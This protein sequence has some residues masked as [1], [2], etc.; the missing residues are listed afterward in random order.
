MNHGMQDRRYYTRYKLN[1][2]N[3]QGEIPFA[4]NVKILNMSLSG[5]LL[6]T[7]KRPDIGNRYILKLESEGKILTLQGIVIRSEINKGNQDSQENIVPTYTVGI[8]FM[9][10]EDEKLIEIAKFIKDHIL[11]D[12]EQGANIT[13]PYQQK[14]DRLRLRLLIEDPERASLYKRQIYY[15]VT[16]ISLSGMRIESEHEM[17]TDEILLMEIR[18]PEKKILSFLGKIMSCNLSEDTVSGMYQ[19]GIEFIDMSEQ[20]KQIL[21]DFIR[22]IKNTNAVQTT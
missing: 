11:D 17:E 14:G 6:K 19:V 3:I 20:D 7:D 1:I 2:T 10:I 22:S 4:K 12:Q 16:N 8:H 13:D 9:N 18:L 5:A 15:Q 21:C